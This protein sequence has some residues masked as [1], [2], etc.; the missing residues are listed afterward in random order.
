MEASPNVFLENLQSTRHMDT[1]Y[2]V[3]DTKQLTDFFWYR[4]SGAV[5]INI[6][7]QDVNVVPVYEDVDH[8]SDNEYMAGSPASAREKERFEEI[9]RKHCRLENQPYLSQL[10]PL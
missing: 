2:Y 1:T 6:G 9:T 4:E 8:V 10:S 5:R 7:L 3:T